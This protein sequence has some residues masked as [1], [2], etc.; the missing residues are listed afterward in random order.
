[1]GQ[2]AVAVCLGGALAGALAFLALVAHE[3]RLL[4]RTIEIRKGW[5]DERRMREEAAQ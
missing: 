4:E 1:M 5:E 2:W 3:L